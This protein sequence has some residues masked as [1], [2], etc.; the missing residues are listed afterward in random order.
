MNNF[1]EKQ[2]PADISYGSSGGPEYYTEVLN[3]TNGCEI[4]SS[5]LY[6]PRMKFNIATGVKNKQQMDE[7][8]RF[9]R[10]CKGR[11]IAF[12]YKDWG[13]FHG[14]NEPVQVIDQHTLQLIKTYN[15]DEYTTEE[16]IITKPVKNTV[17]IQL[18][19]EFISDTQLQIDYTT[20]RITLLNHLMHQQNTKITADFEFDVPVRFDTDY[21]PVIIE[22]YN[23]YSLPNIELVEVKLLSK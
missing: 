4:R 12:R 14:R 6:N 13:D 19:D 15:L 23:F 1:I 5:K 9:F 21:L 17:K 16:R 22:N 2:F 18:N 7:L 3:T 11:N 10:C 20:G 8:I